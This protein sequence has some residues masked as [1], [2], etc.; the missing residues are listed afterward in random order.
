MSRL[1]VLNRT[2]ST[3]LYF[4]EFLISI[5]I[6]GIFSYYLAVLSRRDGANIPQWQRAV[7]GL[8]GAAAL[9]TLFAVIMTCFLGG[10]TFF[11]F[12]AVLL[13]VL[14]CA[15]MVAIAI[16][17]KAATKSC[18][19]TSDDSPIGTGHRTSCQLQKVAFAVAIIGAYVV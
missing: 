7:E 19:S 16:M 15:A 14:F 11:A 10:I 5:L 8:S 17:T 1:H 12:I 3:V 2:A 6:L 13:D 9:Y 4:L 18:A